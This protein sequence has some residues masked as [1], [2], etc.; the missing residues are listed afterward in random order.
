M[1]SVIHF[2]CAHDSVG[3]IVILGSI[4]LDFYRK[5]THFSFPIRLKIANPEILILIQHLTSK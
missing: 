3:L 2:S 5:S 4:E 1:K